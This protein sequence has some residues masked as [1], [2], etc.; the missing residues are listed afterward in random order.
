[1]CFMSMEM[2]VRVEALISII[3]LFTGLS[4][5]MIFK[6]LA[7]MTANYVHSYM[8]GLIGAVKFLL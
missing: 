1:M 8:I 6:G 3:V 5:L 2:W 7:Y 4:N